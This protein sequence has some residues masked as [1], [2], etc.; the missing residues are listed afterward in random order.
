MLK[1]D[2]QHLGYKLRIAMTEKGVTQAAIA[3]E[4]GVKPPT[5]SVDWLKF[6][7]IDK[8]HYSR[9]VSFFNKPYSWWF[10]DVDNE[11]N[12]PEA[13]QPTTSNPDW[14]SLSPQT[15]KLV[16]DLIAQIKIGN[17]DNEDINL[18]SSTLDR[19]TKK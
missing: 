18:I 14:Q 1:N 3:R 4:F 17:L 9:L 7:R 15:R 5:V 13:G 10:G 8:K 12:L 19:L 16:E 11:V 6:G 2:D